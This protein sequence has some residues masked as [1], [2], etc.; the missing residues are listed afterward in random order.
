VEFVAPL[1]HHPMFG[2]QSK[3]PLLQVK[4]GAFLDTNLGLLGSA[5]ESSKYRDVGIEP[6]AVVTPMAG[7]DH[8]SVKIEDALQFSAIE[9][10]NSSPIPRMRKRRDHTQALLTFGL[11]WLRA[12][13][14]A[15]S[16]RSAS[17]CSSSSISRARPG[18]QSSPHGVP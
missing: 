16:R 2:D 9:C 10:R 6:H 3:R 15:T 17:T 18:S 7:S 8:S 12:R 11:G 1:D 5:P 14:S 13:N 4:L